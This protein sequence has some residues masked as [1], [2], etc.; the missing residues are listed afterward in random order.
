M[1]AFSNEPSLLSVP[2][3]AKIFGDIHGQFKDLRK[4]FAKCGN[5][6]TDICNYVFLGDYVDRGP[7]SLAVISL[8]FA[9]KLRYPTRFYLIRGLHCIP[10]LRQ[11]TWRIAA[12]THFSAQLVQRSAQPFGLSDYSACPRVPPLPKM[13]KSL[14]PRW[15]PRTLFRSV[16]LHGAKAHSAER[17]STR[18]AIT[19]AR[20]RP[21]LLLRPRT[22]NHEVEATN[23]DYGFR[24]E[25][26]PPGSHPISA[27]TRAITAKGLRT[28]KSPRGGGWLPLPLAPRTVLR[29]L[30][31]RPPLPGLNCVRRQPHSPLT[32][33]RA[34]PWGRLCRP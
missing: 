2:L 33:L 10:C 16:A 1:R 18:R 22:G 32:A 28:L 14:P 11:R 7:H 15:L 9:L 5:P 29:S 8:L 3:P 27:C 12:H 17:T 34:S 30:L 20:P 23:R 21:H 19:P 4:F 24:D 26:L 6:C 13:P 25:C 31:P